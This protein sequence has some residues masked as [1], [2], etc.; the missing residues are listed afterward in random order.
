[1]T[2]L[3]D[4]P[5]GRLALALAIG[6]IIGTDRERHNRR[7]HEGSAGLRTFALTALLGGLAALSGSAVVAAALAAMVVAL[8]VIAYRRAAPAATGMTSEIALGVTF[9]LGW[10]AQAQPILAVATGLA[11]TLI[12]ACRLQLH[13]FVRQALTPRDL[14]DGLIFLVAALVILPLVSD[15]TVDPW[16]L[17]NP[18]SLWRLTVVLMGL[19]A[20]GYV[21]QRTI[22]PR[23]GLTIAGFVSGFVSSTVAIAAMGARANADAKLSSAAASGAVAAVLGSLSYLIALV[24]ATSPT[25]ALTLWAPFVGA[26][27]P[28]LGFAV[29]LGWRAAHSD[30]GVVA[31]GRA[32]NV[33]LVLV[34]AGLVAVF[35]V[36]GKWLADRLGT[37]GLYAS[38]AATGFVDAHATAVSL[39]TLT[40]TGTVTAPVAATALLIGLTVN[41]AAKIPAAFALGPRPFAWR[42]SAGLALLLAGLWVGF[43]VAALA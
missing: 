20:L 7:H 13:R 10:L 11:V 3:F 36:V 42:V 35:A 40:A 14:L 39:A 32:F 6:L 29:I 23:Y 8:T 25:L 26:L 34:F 9:A 33:P 37:S 5:A 2:A 1:M 30:P 41:M 15:R 16:G 27:L 18:Y 31:S 28:T 38:S 12:L 4:T 21:A 43:G 17:V 24:V 19:S 22:G